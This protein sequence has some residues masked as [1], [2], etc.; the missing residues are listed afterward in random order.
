MGKM[1]VK[2]NRRL[3][4][5]MISVFMGGEWVVFVRGIPNLLEKSLSQAGT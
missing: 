1:V 5:M 4:M 3:R 2:E